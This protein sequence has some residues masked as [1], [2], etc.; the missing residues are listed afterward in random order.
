MI[1]GLLIPPN[2]MLCGWLLCF[3]LTMICPHNVE[4]MT[5]SC[6]ALPMPGR[7]DESLKEWTTL[8]LFPETFLSPNNFPLVSTKLALLCNKRK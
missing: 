7:F 3:Q 4:L 5:T 6:D 8:H 2:G 1:L